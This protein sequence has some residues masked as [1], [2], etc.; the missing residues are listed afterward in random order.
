MA[1]APQQSPQ[2]QQPG[3]GIPPEAQDG[4]RRI[5][6]AGMKA[7][8]D[9]KVSAGIVEILRAGAE[10]PAQALADATV[11][12]VLAL[13]EKAGGKIPKG[14]IIPAA[15]A[16]LRAVAD[17]ASRL[18]VFAI[19]KTVAA[20]AAK[21]VVDGIVAALGN[22]QQAQPPGGQPMSAQPGAEQAPMMGG[23]MVG[24]A[25]QAAGGQQAAA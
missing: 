14:F 7:L 25:M 23:G 16:L 6:M 12:L 22:G 15:Q 20:Q 17:F 1:Q 9:Q 11:K 19:D 10:Q 4:I 18:Q 3:A 2:P 13:Y 5:V 8:Y 24:R 21:L